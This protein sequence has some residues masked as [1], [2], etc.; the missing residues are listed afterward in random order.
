MELSNSFFEQLFLPLSKKEIILIDFDNKHG[1]DM[2][3]LLTNKL[4][5]ELNRLQINWIK[6]NSY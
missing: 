1:V 6:I 4:Y 2:Y 5:N 3:N